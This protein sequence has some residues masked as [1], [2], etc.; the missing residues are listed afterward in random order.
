MTDAPKTPTI[1]SIYRAHAVV[2][3]ISI[4]VT[5]QGPT[6]FQWIQRELSAILNLT[7]GKRIHVKP[8]AGAPGSDLVPYALRFHDE[9]ANSIH[10]LRR[11]MGELG[12]RFPMA[13]PPY[14]DGIELALDFYQRKEGQGDLLAMTRQLQESIAAYDGNPRLYAPD[15]KRMDVLGGGKHGTRIDPTK[16]MRIGH[17]SADLQW[18]VYFKTTDEVKTKQ[19]TTVRHLPPA[20]HRARAEVTLSRQALA[21]HTGIERIGLDD[22][23][24]LKFETFA[25][26][27]L[28]FLRFKP[29]VAAPGSVME[30]AC[31]IGLTCVARG[32]GRM[33]TRKV[34]PE[35]GEVKY[36]RARKHSRM[37]EAHPELN[38]IARNKLRD[39]TAAFGK[40]IC[41]N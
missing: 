2:D 7:P 22:L 11:I 39:L 15:M 25:K 24:Q 26:D 32:M 5:P 30:Q 34:D 36:S 35:T 14:V 17:N 23:A 20:Q 29:F 31:A 1:L 6:Q 18:R 13:Q 37:T 41:R 21:Q 19:G 40:E 10:E 4:V 12:R 28:Q 3:W 27:H 33:K 38:Q 9:H 16:T 8:C